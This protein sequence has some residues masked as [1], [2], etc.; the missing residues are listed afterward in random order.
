MRELS[1]LE[2][3]ECNV[4]KSTKERKDFFKNLLFLAVFSSFPCFSPSLCGIHCSHFFAIF[5]CQSSNHRNTR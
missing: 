5:A 3:N 4:K 1:N 2:W